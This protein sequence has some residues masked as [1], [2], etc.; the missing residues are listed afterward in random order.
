MNSIA[1]CLE[2]SK[3]SIS[4]IVAR[5]TLPLLLAA[6]G[7]QVAAPALAQTCRFDD[8]NSSLAVEGLILTRYA[9]GITGA[10]LVASTGINAVDAPTAEA[11][12]NCPSCGL[13]IT[14]NAA[15]TVAD[16]TIIS[17]KLAGFSGA[18]LTNGVALGSGIRNTD[19]A[20]QSFPLSGCGASL[21]LPASCSTNQIFK[22]NGTTW[23]CAT[24][25][26]TLQSQLT[27]CLIGCKFFRRA[28]TAA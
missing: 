22:W 3:R 21:P 11:A 23:V 13:N 7:A 12:I 28:V 4:R 17:R 20:V 26:P 2:H 10:P 16:A 9:V 14:G 19:V 27:A 6:L 8:G 24:P 25:S 15:F 1:Q 5:M 18:A